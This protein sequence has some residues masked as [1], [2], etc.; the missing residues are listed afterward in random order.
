MTS[1]AYDKRL[2]ATPISGVSRLSRRSASRTP[3]GADRA[4]ICPDERDRDGR[5]RPA[6]LRRAASSCREYSSTAAAPHV[7]RIVTHIVDRRRLQEIDRHVADGKGEPLRRKLAMMDAEKAK[8]VRSPALHEVQIARVID[9]A[10]KIRVLE[11]D[12]LCGAVARGRQAAGKARRGLSSICR[13]WRRECGRSTALCIFCSNVRTMNS[14]GRMS[15]ISTSARGFRQGRPPASS[16][17][18]GR[19]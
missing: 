13:S 16:W 12:A 18:R 4:A 7:V 15:A 17:R 8:I 14:A 1:K 2:E 10:G 9:A 5:A 11:I 6:A 19:F 3:A